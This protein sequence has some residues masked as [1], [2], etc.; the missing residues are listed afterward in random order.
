MLIFVKILD[1]IDEHVKRM[2]ANKITCQTS[3]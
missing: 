1:I 2:E 3:L